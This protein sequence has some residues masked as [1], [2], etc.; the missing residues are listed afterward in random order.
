MEN[1]EVLEALELI[2]NLEEED[3]SEQERRLQRKKRIEE[4]RRKKNQAELIQRCVV[5]IVAGFLL[6][7]G[8]GAGILLRSSL[9]KAADVP[10]ESTQLAKTGERENG[11]TSP[12]GGIQGILQGGDFGELEG[13]ESNASG[14]GQGD[15]DIEEGKRKA[16]YGESAK[17]GGAGTGAE[18]EESLPAVFEASPTSVTAGFGEEIVSDYG[19]LI[20]VEN[21]EI[22]AGKDYRGRISPASMTKIL[23]VLTAAE[24]LGI[25]DGTEEVLYDIFT[26]TVEITDYCYVN[27]CSTAWFSV[28]E[29]IPIRDLFYGTI[30]PSG[31]DAA[32]GLATYVA[33]SQE[34]FMELMNRKVEAMGLS[35][36]THFTN[37]VGLYDED[38][39]STVY[40]IAVILKEAADNPFCRKVLSAHT[41]SASPTEEH[42]EGL[43]WSNWFLRRIEDR[44]THGEVLC[45]KTGFV[46]QSRSCAASLSVDVDGR[47]YLCVT[48][49][50]SSSWQCIADQHMLYATYLPAAE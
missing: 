39:Y 49:G 48:A 43:M 17:G 6:I 36:S 42:P 46:N 40:D 16:G 2:D 22:I 25:T 35:E 18:P 50:S 5:A 47:E 23:T 44:D 31:A 45:G 9:K 12:A 10:E 38:H 11:D 24:A 33:G 37:C 4:M 28:G 13:S 41:Y 1:E 32:V 14:N 26:M 7:V 34:A 19:I 20:D 30:L 27:D 15:T 29:E 8:V 21:Q 3:E